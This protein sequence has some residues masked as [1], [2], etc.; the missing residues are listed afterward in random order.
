MGLAMIIINIFLAIASI[1]ALLTNLFLGNFG[2]AWICVPAIAY[3]VCNLIAIG[4]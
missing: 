3:F 2:I 4:G 1:A